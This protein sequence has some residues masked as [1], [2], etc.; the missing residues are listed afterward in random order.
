MS[1][2]AMIIWLYR[3][4]GGG[5]CGGARQPGSSWKGREQMVAVCWT[6]AFELD[7]LAAPK[8][9]VGSG[10]VLIKCSRPV[11]KSSAQHAGGRLQQPATSNQQRNAKT[12][13]CSPQVWFNVTDESGQLSTRPNES[14][15]CI[16]TSNAAFTPRLIIQARLPISLTRPYPTSCPASALRRRN[17]QCAS[18]RSALFVHSHLRAATTHVP[19]SLHHSLPHSQLY[20]TRRRAPISTPPIWT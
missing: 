5:M 13:P 19:D 8:R 10:K 15:N 17:R 3:S 6:R 9:Y 20:I 7:C 12:R 14:D 11:C 1:M 18:P 16:R 4:G 2:S